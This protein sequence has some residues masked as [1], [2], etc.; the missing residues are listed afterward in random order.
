MP[1]D[2][3]I[4]AE[5]L[6]A[7]ALIL[8]I[9]YIFDLSVSMSSDAEEGFLPISAE[10]LRMILWIGCIVLLAISFVIGINVSSTMLTGILLMCGAVLG[11]SL[12]FSFIITLVEYNTMW[13]STM[14]IIPPQIIG[15]ISLGYLIM[16]LGIFRITKKN[17]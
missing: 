5:A 12:L 7:L 17:K 4:A 13:G 9:V 6:S 16:G 10:K 15:M 11:T 2:K 3:K 14:Q 8:L 1:R